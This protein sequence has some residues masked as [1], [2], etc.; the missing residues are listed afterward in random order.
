MR[1]G[2]RVVGVDLTENQIVEAKARGGGVT[3]A[4]S[5]AEHLPFASGSFDALVICLSLEHM[6]PFEPAVEEV[7][8]VLAPGGCFLL[9]LNHP[10]LQAPNSGWIDDH[11]LEEQYWRVGPYLHDD[12]SME[13]V[14]PGIKLPFMHRPL[15]PI[16]QR[17]GNLRAARR[18]HGRTAASAGIP[19]PGTRVRR[20][21][22][23]PQTARPA[24][25]QAGVSIATV[26]PRAPS[27]P[28]PVANP[29]FTTRLRAALARPLVACVVLLGIYGCLSLL[30]DPR[31]FLGTDTG[32][33]VATIRAMDER[34]DLDPDVGYWAERFD[35]NGVAHP[36]ALT[37]HVGDQWLNV[38]TLPMLYAAVPLYDVGGLRGILLL[39]MLGAVLAALAARALSR[40]LGG[41]GT[42]AFWA[43]GLATPVAVYALD[44][45][46][47]SLGLAA[48][49][50]GV[51]LLIDVARR[52]AGWKATLSAGVLFGLAATMRTEALVYA[53]AAIG[54]TVLV[55]WWGDR[56]L[57]AAFRTGTIAV[58]GV[59]I[60]L[61]CNNAVR[62]GGARHQLPRGPRVARR[63]DAR[64]R[65]RKP[66]HAT[67]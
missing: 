57:G 42:L 44:F 5:A 46:E 24:R 66:R 55:T 58:A 45:W 14:A 1:A 36:L 34:G 21:G 2:A 61:V 10:L 13:E 25:P 32:A 18:A 4:R 16:H 7:G 27:E 65:R 60:P 6:E 59:A 40:R 41:D 23:D 35:R 37:R 50:W 28:D 64:Q 8:R 47:H 51:V 62:A 30:N 39:P 9:F 11:I 26:P 53:V 67:P 54:V 17:D 48:M 19:R 22:L 49:L 33:K 3:Y 63:A 20:G 43:V 52:A 56:K 38:T 15:E 12:V 29:S 31:A